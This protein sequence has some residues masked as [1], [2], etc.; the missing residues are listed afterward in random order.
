MGISLV[1]ADTI[2]PGTIS[3][4]LG[5][6]R[7]LRQKGASNRIAD[8]LALSRKH[9]L[10][11]CSS[12]SI[13][14]VIVTLATGPAL[15]FGAFYCFITLLQHATSACACHEYQEHETLGIGGRRHH[16]GTTGDF[17]RNRHPARTTRP[18]VK[19]SLD[20][21]AKAVSSEQSSSRRIALG[22][23]DGGYYGPSNAPMPS[24]V[25]ADCG[26]EMRTPKNA[27]ELGEM[28]AL[29][30][31]NPGSS[32]RQRSPLSISHWLRKWRRT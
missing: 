10:P 5:P 30:G 3:Q 24:A 1:Q 4:H 20:S 18:A 22:R 25:R 14:T 16:L 29:Q 19:D 26:D 15:Q 6:E 8:A 31:G 11:F 2:G 28:I 32:R 9:P 12:R 17:S 7:G 13:P 23:V 21:V 27:Q